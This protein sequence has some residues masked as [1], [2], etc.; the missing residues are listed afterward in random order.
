MKLARQ[1]RRQAEAYWREARRT[2]DPDHRQQHAVLAARFVEMAAKYEDDAVIA[3]A[4]RMRTQ[5]NNA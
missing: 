2:G 5:Q 4:L 1:F 3:R